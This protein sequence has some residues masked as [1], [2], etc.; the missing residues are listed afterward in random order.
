MIKSCVLHPWWI[1]STT[2]RPLNIPFIHYHHHPYSHLP[3]LNTYSSL[4]FPNKETPAFTSVLSNK[5][6]YTL[7]HT[8]FLL[9][10]SYHATQTLYL[11]QTNARIKHTAVTVSPVLNRITV[12][13]F[14]SWSFTCSGKSSTFYTK[15]SHPSSHTL[16]V[17]TIS[18]L[19]SCILLM[20]WSDP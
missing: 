18:H 7:S 15:N 5:E 11:S 2:H 6:I 8:Y 10:K 17:C 4:Y 19:T 16:T 13:P 14:Y 20:R 12:C 9:R 3:F 1:Y